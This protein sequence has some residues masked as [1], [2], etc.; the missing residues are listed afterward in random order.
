MKCEDNH[1]GIMEGICK[2]ATVPHMKACYNN[3]RVEKLRETNEYLKLIARISTG[4]SQLY[5]RRNLFDESLDSVKNIWNV[6]F[7]EHKCC[8]RSSSVS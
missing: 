7:T 8:S 5:S 4:T 3:I 1:A 2:D 6:Q